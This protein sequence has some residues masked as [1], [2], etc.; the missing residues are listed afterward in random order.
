MIILIIQRGINYEQN[1][2]VYWN[3]YG[4]DAIGIEE[5]CRQISN[6]TTEE[7]ISIIREELRLECLM[8][9][10]ILAVTFKKPNCMAKNDVMFKSYK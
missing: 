6:H 4:D 9:R 8:C 2:Y 3:V 7:E 5:C 10:G 1:W